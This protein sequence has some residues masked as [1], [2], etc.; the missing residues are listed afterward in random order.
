MKKKTGLLCTAALLAAAVV[1]GG[2][3]A[4]YRAETST[5]KNI[6]IGKL[7]IELVQE[8]QNGASAFQKD[9]AAGYRYSA[10]PNATI[11]NSIKIKSTEEQPLYLR[12]TVSKAWY[13]SQGEKV[14]EDEKGRPI[15]AGQ[16]G[17]VT[18]DPSKWIISEDQDSYGEVVYFYYTDPIGGSYE[19]ETSNLMDA[20]TVLKDVNEPTNQYADLSVGITFE[21]EAVQAIGGA[22]T[23]TAAM[24]S[25]WGVTPQFADDGL[26]L[27]A[28]DDG[29]VLRTAR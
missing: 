9:G 10:A 12:V 17:L 7:G 1:T 14:F 5:Q 6:S 26:T 19:A 27:T 20:F 8:G 25:E 15:D 24:E 21:A 13:D 16:I 4:A 29:G 3:M 18:E 28:V 11:D 2:T 23:A 22:A